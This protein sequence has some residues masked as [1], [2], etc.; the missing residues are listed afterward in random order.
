ML[1]LVVSLRVRPEGRE[2]VLEAIRAQAAASLEREPG[3]VRF[4]VTVDTQDPHHLV[5]FEVY[6]DEDAMAA[7]R[8][9]PHFARWRG[10]SDAHVARR[11]I[12]IATIVAGS[13]A[14]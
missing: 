6:R 10:V 2:I 8:A 11:E 12:T 9:T 3:C 1:A 14:G 5:L 7:H 4:D 13:D